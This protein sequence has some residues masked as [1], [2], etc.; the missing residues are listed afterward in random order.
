MN[1]AVIVEVHGVTGSKMV[2]PGNNRSGIC[3]HPLVY[4]VTACKP[5]QG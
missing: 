5:Q 1:A 4:P 3:R 2:A